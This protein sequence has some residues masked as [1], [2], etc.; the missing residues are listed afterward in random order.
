MSSESPYIGSK[1][2]LIS[3]AKI[4]YEGV[5]YTIDTE[6]ATVALSKVRSFGTEDRECDRPVAPREE[7]YEYI[8]FRGT[9]IEDLTV[10]EP[11]KPTPSPS[12]TS[13]PQDPAIVQSVVTSQPSVQPPLP[14]FA[15][16]LPYG[17]MP[18]SSYPFMPPP[19]LPYQTM[20]PG[21]PLDA[22]S[23]PPN[24]QS[25]LHTSSQASSARGEKAASPVS[26]GRMSPTSEQGVQA[27]SPS[28]SPLEH[29]QQRPSHESNNYYNNRN[30]NEGGVHNFHYSDHDSRR[31]RGGYRQHS[32]Y[33]NRG[34]NG[35]QG[36]RGRGQRRNYY[37]GQYDHQSQSYRG[38]RTQRGGRRYT[39][40]NDPL[41]FDGDF[42]FEGSNAQFNKEDIAKELMEKLK[43]TSNVAKEENKV[44]D[45]TTEE[46]V[47]SGLDSGHSNETAED[48]DGEDSTYYDKSKS[49]FDSITCETNNPRGERMSW[50]EERKRNNE[51][52]G[53]PWRSRGRGYR[54][55]RGG[56]YRGGRGQYRGRGRGG[57]DGNRRNNY[58]SRGDQDYNQSDNRND[59][60]YRRGG[61]RG[62]GNRGQ[63][64]GR[65]WVN[66]EYKYEKSH[67]E[68]QSSDPTAVAS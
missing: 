66:Y 1:I 49:F 31:G 48:S 59:D 32:G 56:G 63:S 29:S 41:R 58:Y 11:P 5:L 15:G 14:P 44:K 55:N 19:R 4:R 20:A 30:R 53:T 64:K 26:L 18:P 46:K 39:P 47:D 24:A 27:G 2:S 23:K 3:K 42:D 6:N 43:I 8:I 10:C 36:N 16:G 35:E 9:D 22:Q 33:D 17:Q 21:Q 13:L 62:G 50:T 12:A 60:G 40:R 52:F 65:R 61:Y 57:Y 34:R 54:G 51:T 68:K 37:R 7:V 38:Q 67:S 28:A 45:G 25:T